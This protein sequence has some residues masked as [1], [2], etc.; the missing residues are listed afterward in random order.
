ML[1]PTSGTT[2][3]LSA[4]EDCRGVDCSFF[5]IG[6]KRSPRRSKSS[7]SSA[8]V[9][10]KT[11]V[12]KSAISTRI[13][14]FMSS[15]SMR[16]PLVPSWFARK[17]ILTGSNRPAGKSLVLRKIGISKCDCT[18]ALNAS[19]LVSS[20]VSNSSPRC[21]SS[22]RVASIEASGAPAGDVVCVVSKLCS[23]RAKL[24]YLPCASK[25]AEAL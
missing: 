10:R 7:T 5:K 20:W 3:Q 12:S 13:P 17:T 25:S 9:A 16:T 15:F 23:T 6:I 19:T 14:N 2:D 11:I 21:A 24:R 8:R 22:A 18:R 1:V 4:V